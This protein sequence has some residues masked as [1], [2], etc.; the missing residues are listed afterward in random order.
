LRNHSRSVGQGAIPRPPGDE[1]RG[2]AASSS[3]DTARRPACGTGSRA[4][5]LRRCCTSDEGFRVSAP[6]PW[7]RCGRKR[8][9]L[10]R[11]RMPSSDGAP[12][13]WSWMANAAIPLTQTADRITELIQ[14]PEHVVAA[15]GA[16]RARPSRT[17]PQQAAPE[18][19]SSWL[20]L[21]SARRPQT[22][23]AVA[24]DVRR[25][26]MARWLPWRMRIAPGCANHLDAK[27]LGSGYGAWLL[28]ARGG[29]SS[30]PIPCSGVRA[31]GLSSVISWSGDVCD[32]LGGVRN[33]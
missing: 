4:A 14:A 12:R 7:T 11:R 32:R 20:I 23:R 29:V 25:G 18:V 28:G 1:R 22:C 13:R 9:R 26:R 2:V 27:I 33:T 19:G 21:I 31:G 15:G 16:R 5:P 17:K 6:F 10:A 30:G 24:W 8:S 3:L